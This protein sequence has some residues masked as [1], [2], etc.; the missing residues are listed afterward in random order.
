MAEACRALDLPVIGGNV[1]LYN[2]SAGIDIDPTPVVAVLGIIDHLERRPPGMA[3]TAGSTLVLLGDTDRALAGSRWAVERHGEGGA[4]LPVLDLPA[5]ARLVAL[6]GRIVPVEGMLTSIHD[7]SGG[8][9]ALALA[10]SA[11]RSGVGCRVDGVA[12]HAELFS[13]SSSRVVLGTQR[14]DEV[15]AGA[16]A[17]GVPGRVIG[18]AGGDRI[19]V[20]G[21]LDIA[22]AEAAEAWRV[23]LP[24]ALGEPV[25]A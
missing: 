20:T 16:A 3:F 21:L 14:P 19:V 12:D 5:H 25:T 15:L 13:E 2:A 6:L 23:A 7:I 1:S 9:L 11:L 22:V 8:G 4:T 17:A 24:G 10:E 18:S